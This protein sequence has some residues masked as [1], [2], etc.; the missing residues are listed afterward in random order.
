MGLS[1]VLNQEECIRQ[2]LESPKSWLF[3]PCGHCPCLLHLCGP[4]LPFPGAGGGAWTTGFEGSRG[5]LG[6]RRC[7]C[8]RPRSQGPG[9]QGPSSVLFKERC[10]LSLPL[11]P[12]SC[13]FLSRPE[14]WASRQAF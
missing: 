14:L 1:W 2:W 10:P 3:F 9:E 4:L 7:R 13:S 11:P 12:Q 5:F 6:I 8:W